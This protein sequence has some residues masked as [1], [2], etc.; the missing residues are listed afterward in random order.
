[1]SSFP[2]YL[3]VGCLFLILVG[4]AVIDA[5]PAG[6]VEEYLKIVSL[7]E[8][9]L[10]DASPSKGTAQNYAEYPLI[11]S[12]QDGKKEI[13]RVTVDGNGNYRVALPPGDY[14]LGRART[15]QVMSMASSSLKPLCAPSCGQPRT[16]SI[17]LTTV[18]PQLAEAFGV[19]RLVW[20]A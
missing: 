16:T 18:R 19:S 13:T 10:A 4:S 15:K 14:I 2:N 6:F 20:L 17:L 5:A 12:S 9:E 8:V 1:M 11:V 7:K 3:S